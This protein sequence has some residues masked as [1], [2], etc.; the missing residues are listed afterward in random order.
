MFGKSLLF[1]SETTVLKQEKEI[2]LSVHV[3]LLKIMSSKD[4]REQQY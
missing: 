4:A 3:L 2:S 1:C